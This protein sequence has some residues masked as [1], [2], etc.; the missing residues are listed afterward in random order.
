MITL[1]TAVPGSGKSLYTVQMIDEYLAKRDPDPETPQERRP[2]RMVYTNIP[3]HREKFTQ[4]ENIT[5]FETPDIGSDADI[6]DW[7]EAPIGSLVIYDEA[8]F[9]FPAKIKNAKT[10]EIVTAMSTHRHEGY[11]IYVITQDPTLVN[12]PVRKLAGQHIH[13]YRAFGVQGATKYVWQ[14]AVNDPNSRYEQTR[15][16]QS[17]F[18]FPRHYYDYYVSAEQHTHKLQLPRKLVYLIMLLIGVTAYTVYGFYRDGGI[19]FM[20][21]KK[22]PAVDAAKQAP[23]ATAAVVDGAVPAA[24]PLQQT[25]AVVPDVRELTYGWSSTP[26]AASLTGCVA[27]KKRGICQC[28]NAEGDTVALD[29]AQ[30]LSTLAKP[31]PRNVRLT[32]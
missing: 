10:E 28:F 17:L 15:A 20:G 11:D 16:V 7:R 21:G 23:A 30:C 5:L 2:A 9:F 3:L 26:A 8:Q 14:H 19:N 12:S 22:P 1:I 6:F 31:I 29:H 32:R 4:P 25:E 13:L 24:G 27:N 18:R